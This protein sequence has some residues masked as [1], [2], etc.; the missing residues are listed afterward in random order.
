MRDLANNVTL[1]SMLP[2]KQRAAG[3]VTATIDLVGE[4][5][6][7]EMIVDVGAVAL[8]GTLNVVVTEC[9]TVGGVYTSLYTFAQITAVGTALLDLTPT[10]RF[11]KVTATVAVAAIDFAVIV[12]AYCE[13]YRPSNVTIVP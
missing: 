13:R 5:R 10:K 7:L 11:V 2:A 1:I 8:N 9:D 4:G 3:A 12:A 6:K